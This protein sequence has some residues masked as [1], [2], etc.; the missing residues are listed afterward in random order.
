MSAPESLDEH[1]GGSGPPARGAPGA[2]LQQAMSAGAGASAQAA[3]FYLGRVGRLTP[4][5]HAVITVSPDAVAEARAS[6]GVRAI[7]RP[8][9]P[10]EGIPVLVKDNIATRGMPATAGSPALLGAASADAFLVG[11]LREAG[12]VIVGKANL[13]ESANFRSPHS[14]SGLSTLGGQA[15][16][17]AGKA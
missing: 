11:R 6:D 5:L 12:A 16:N 8:R 9:G 2:R 17:P 14:T 3:P 1:I 7:G 10:L 15:G 13:S 4:D